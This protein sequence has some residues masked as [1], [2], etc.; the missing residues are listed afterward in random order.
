MVGIL[1]ISQLTAFHTAETEFQIKEG[2]E[3]PSPAGD[4]L[5]NGYTHLRALACV[6]PDSPDLEVCVDAGAGNSITGRNLLENG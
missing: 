4:S 2:P 6:K 5:H 1:E 3:S